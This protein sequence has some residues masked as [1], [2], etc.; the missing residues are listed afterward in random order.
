MKLLL[1]IIFSILTIVTYSQQEV[2][3]IMKNGATKKAI[4]LGEKNDVYSFK[5]IE[6]GNKFKIP[7]NNIQALV[8]GCKYEKNQVDDM[9]GD[10]VK[11]STWKTLY[12]LFTKL[13]VQTSQVN[14]YKYL[15]IKII[16]GSIFTIPAEATIIFKDK[17]GQT[18][19]LK[20]IN[21][22]GEVAEGYIIAGQTAYTATISMTLDEATIK[23]LA[24]NN[25]SKVR[26]YYRDG[27]K[28]YEIKPGK[29]G[30]LMAVMSCL[31]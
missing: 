23:G 6:K 14:D 13:S 2:K 19:Q 16:D 8:E 20:T 27:Y 4:L 22:M 11:S 21:E 10:K 12:N 3:I 18:Y 25:L 15:N 29:V 1:V 7:R 26:I 9:T 17:S 30:Q 31:Q 28:D 5:D 24:E